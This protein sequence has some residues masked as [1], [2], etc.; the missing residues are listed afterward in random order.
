M[1]TFKRRMIVRYY[2][3]GDEASGRQATFTYMLSAEAH[4][5]GGF[6][7]ALTGMNPT[8]TEGELPA[9]KMHIRDTDNVETALLGAQARINSHHAGL[10]PSAHFVEMRISRNAFDDAQVDTG[11]G[12]SEVRK[13][14]D[15]AL[16][17]GDPVIVTEPD[18]G[19]TKVGRDDKGKFTFTPIARK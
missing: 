11:L 9:G 3:P 15:E 5:A 2:S 18:G 17:N 16:G 19:E 13:Q 4:A 8:P 12:G 10:K 7:V 1:S 14:I 6:T